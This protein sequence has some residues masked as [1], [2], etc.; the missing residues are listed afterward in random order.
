M[1]N[2]LGMTDHP[3][4]RGVYRVRAPPSA[5]VGGSSPLARG[6]PA[7]IGRA[8]PPPRIIPARAGFTPAQ[9]GGSTGSGDHPRSR[10]VYAR[11][12]P[13]RRGHQRII[14]ARA[15][16]TRTTCS[17][18]LVA[19][20]HPR[21]RGVYRSPPPGWPPGRGSSPLARGLRADSLSEMAASGIIPARAGF[22]CKPAPG[23]CA[24]WDHPRSRGVYIP[25]PVGRRRGQGSSP[26]ARGLPDQAGVDAPAG[27]IIPAR[28][29]FTPGV[30]T[31]S[32]DSEDHPR[33]RGVYH[34]GRLCGAQERGSSPLA[35]GLPRASSHRAAIVRIIPARAGFTVHGARERAHAP[36]H[37]RSRGVYRGRGAIGS[38]SR[39]SS[40]LARGLRR[41]RAP[42][43]AGARIIP[44]RA[45]FTCQGSGWRVH[46]Q[47]HPRSRGVYLGMSISLA[48][49]IGSSPLAR[50]LHKPEG[51]TMNTI[52]IIPA[53]AGFTAGP[54]APVRVLWDHPRS[55]GVYTG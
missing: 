18:P 17:A 44:A 9:P 15:G 40:P 6:L 49:I 53:R 45:G 1:A 2:A 33:S 29:G 37:P 16:F 22:T 11:R 36:D 48:E 54:T 43:P 32:G 27:G 7:W 34:R 5:I 46:H 55:R 35:R 39:G 41:P 19:A 8:F 25:R 50:G 24:P 38:P 20:D 30:V 14:P 31:Q 13:L 28:A 52:G 26:L 21:S 42:I 51:T 3:R 23:H 47:D 4:S 12:R 10:G